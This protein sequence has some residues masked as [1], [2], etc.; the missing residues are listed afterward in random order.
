MRLYLQEVKIKSL[1]VN[2][3]EFLGG[4]VKLYLTK[5]C[6]NQGACLRKDLWFMFCRDNCVAHTSRVLQNA[7][8]ANSR[9]I[10]KPNCCHGDK[11][12]ELLS[13]FQQRAFEFVE[14][15]FESLNMTKYRTDR[16]KVFRK[17]NKVCCLRGS[18]FCHAPLFCS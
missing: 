14:Y 12:N 15:V 4:T 9:T 13:V 7:K 11:T 6:T 10:F 18:T 5:Y 16:N 3:S 1:F 2:S 17:C 8:N